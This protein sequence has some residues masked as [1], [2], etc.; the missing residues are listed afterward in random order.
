MPSK[1]PEF[2][3]E[4]LAKFETRYQRRKRVRYDGSWTPEDRRRYQIWLKLT[5]AAERRGLYKRVGIE[6]KRTSPRLAALKARTQK[7]DEVPPSTPP[8]L[9]TSEVDPLEQTRRWIDE[10]IPKYVPD[11]PE[12]EL[13]EDP[14]PPWY[15]FS[16]LSECLVM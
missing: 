1:L 7:A 8:A 5:K 6:R 15:W 13:M 2:T 12:E 10:P 4:E 14:S 16:A 9:S 11:P 3:G